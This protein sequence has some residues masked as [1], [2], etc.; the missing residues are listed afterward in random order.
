PLLSVNHLKVYFPIKVGVLQRTVDYVKAVEEV[1]FKVPS[2][3]TFA[4][5]GESGS[6]KTTIAKGIVRL[7]QPSGGQ[8]NFLG[9]ELTQLSHT[10]FRQ[11][12]GD[13]Q[14]VFQDPYASMNPRM[15]IVHIIAEGMLAQKIA[16]SLAECIP[17]ISELLKRV[18]LSDDCLQ[19][20][21][22]EFSGGQR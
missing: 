9:Q 17:T 13:L 22:H 19:R 21:P 7:V 4:L 18:D 3:Q 20:F 10:H 12:R 15:R 8:V 6:G 5:V 14:M 16:G 1:S 11:L 2:G